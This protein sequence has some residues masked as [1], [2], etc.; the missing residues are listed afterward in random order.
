MGRLKGVFRPFV[1]QRTVDWVFRI[2]TEQRIIWLP[3]SP[4]QKVVCQ[5]RLAR[6]S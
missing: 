5:E 3:L 2:T 6:I 1:L 4:W